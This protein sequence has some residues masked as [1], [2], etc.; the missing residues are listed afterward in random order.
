MNSSEAV[1]LSPYRPPTS[2][3]VN[4][5][6]EEAEAWLNGSFVLWHPA[7]LALLGRVPSCGST[8]DHDAPRE[9]W[10]Y[11]I[12]AGPMLYQPDNWPEL[13][14]D[15]KAVSFAATP[16]AGA[17]L[18]NLK[19]ALQ[20]Y[21]QRNSDKE[22]SASL[23]DCAPE[24]VLSFQAVGYA[25][26]LIETLYD[27]ASHD[28]MLD[29]AGFWAD[30]QQAVSCV[31]EGNTGGVRAALKLAVEKLT[32]ARTVLN[33][34]NLRIVDMAL[35]N[36]ET[37][38]NEW[39]ASLAAGLPLTVMAS[40][41]TLENQATQY[42]ERFAELRS[43]FHDQLPS[44]VDLAIG[45]YR[46]R[47]DAN[48]PAESQFWNW[49]EAQRSIQKQFG[50]SLSVA[51]RL[52]TSFH[53]QTPS[54]LLHAGYKNAVLLAFDGALTPG[55]NAVVANWT[56]P[57]GKGLDSFARTPLDA[58]DPLTFFNLGCS[59]HSAFNSD[60]SPTVAFRHGQHPA[61][62]GYAQL[63]ALAELGEACGEWTSL[64]RLLGETHYGDYLGQQ[65]ADD[66]FNDT[67]DG[68]VLR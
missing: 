23:V 49:R 13:V 21:L 25:H 4:L 63:V 22:L 64:G 66:Y 61:A 57:D 48:L 33:S 43:K 36:A 40:A 58:S 24:L 27:A 38:N 60:S 30:V 5:N 59:M 28:R 32:Y 31:V 6:P 29:E 16:D 67:L 10:I 8:H 45:S 56:G 50:V 26:S 3:A 2:Y 39:P 34:N 51:G 62:V 42:P 46:E 17:T 54:W 12:P 47:D 65:T 37:L 1:L 55:R 11:C 20:T 15:A 41:E 44:S 18:A 68:V 9:G 14:A 7:L 53:P 35:R 19:E 52:R